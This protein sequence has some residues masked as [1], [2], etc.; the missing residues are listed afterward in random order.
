MIMNYDDR[1]GGRRTGGRKM[2]KDATDIL[3]ESIVVDRTKSIELQRILSTCST[4][5]SKAAAVQGYCHRSMKCN[6][7][8]RLQMEVVPSLLAGASWEAL[9][10]KLDTAFASR[11][12][13]SEGGVRYYRM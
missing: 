3:L 5:Q 7:S 10:E 8:G 2:G 6:L 11:P 9:A 4:V 13:A 1:A 12:A